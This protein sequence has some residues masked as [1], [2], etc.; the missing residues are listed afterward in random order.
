MVKSLDAS[1]KSSW[2][3]P[4]SLSSV[5]DFLGKVEKSMESKLFP[6]S[7]EYISSYEE[8]PRAEAQVQSAEDRRHRLDEFSHSSWDD[9]TLSSNFCSDHDNDDTKRRSGK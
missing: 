3:V 8:L 4:A 9:D 5:S 2:K 7:E 6:V 1:N